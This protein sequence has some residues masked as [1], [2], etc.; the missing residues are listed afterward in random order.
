MNVFTRCLI[1]VTVLS[2]ILLEPIAAEECDCVKPCPHIYDPVCGT[3]DGQT[4]RH[5]ANRCMMEAQNEC[6]CNTAG[7]YLE[8]SYSNCGSEDDNWTEPDYE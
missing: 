2:V 7:E 1:A 5:F 3:K 4:Y 8:T 6:D